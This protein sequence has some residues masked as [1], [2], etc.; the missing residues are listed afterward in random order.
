MCLKSCAEFPL[1][2][3]MCSR[4][5][6]R[7]QPLKKNE[8]V[9]VNILYCS[10]TWGKYNSLFWFVIPQSFHILPHPQ[11][12]AVCRLCWTNLSQI[13][14][15]V[16]NKSSQICLHTYKNVLR[17]WR[18]LHALVIFFV[19]Y[20]Y[21]NECD[22]DWMIKNGWGLNIPKCIIYNMMYLYVY[23]I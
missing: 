17:S 11:E 23:I 6:I 4:Y 19:S 12:E 10:V 1:N 18:N 22:A 8:I 13:C 7:P 2:R 9:L 20:K 5:A 3:T 14:K 16:L 21:E 15:N